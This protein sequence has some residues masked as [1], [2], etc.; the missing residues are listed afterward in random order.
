MAAQ[1]ILLISILTDGGVVGHGEG[2]VPGGPW[3]VGESVETMKAIVDRY[4]YR[5]L[6]GE[7]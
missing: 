3:W 6:L 5:S 2:V 4:F 1:P 7:P